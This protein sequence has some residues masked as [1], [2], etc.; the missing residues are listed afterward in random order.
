MFAA[1]SSRDAA[2]LRPV[3]DQGPRSNR[4]ALLQGNRRPQR[5]T[6]AVASAFRYLALP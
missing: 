2:F 5:K 3:P 4:G 6:D 1:S